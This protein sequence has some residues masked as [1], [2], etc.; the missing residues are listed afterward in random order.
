MTGPPLVFLDANI[1]FS[2]APGGPV[3]EFLLDLA[4]RGAIR[5]TT[6]RACVIEAE[7]NL[8]RKRQ[9][10]HGA[11]APILAACAV[12][13]D[14]EADEHL[15]WAGGLVGSDDVHV[16]AA[17]RRTGAEVLLTGDSTHFGKLMERTDLGLKVRTPRG[18]L[19]EGPGRL[20]R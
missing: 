17:A 9:D 7:T 16:L 5:P 10:R 8:E 6:S 12:E 20:R 13:A 1:L 4:A 15:A 2:A 19:L 11:L 14:V 18:F 3:F